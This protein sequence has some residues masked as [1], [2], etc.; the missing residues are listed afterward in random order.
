MYGNLESWKN[1][2]RLK[3]SIHVK[4]TSVQST[5]VYTYAGL[6]VLMIWA[7]CLFSF[8]M[9]FLLRKVEDVTTISK[10][11]SLISVRIIYCTLRVSNKTS[12]LFLYEQ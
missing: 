5:F 1:P 4:R 2:D 9:F 3:L 10:L 6:Q 11:Q 8:D 7:N 12:T